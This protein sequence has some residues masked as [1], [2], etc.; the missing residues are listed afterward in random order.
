MNKILLYLHKAYDAL[1]LNYCLETLVAHGVGPWDFRLLQ[2]YL[3]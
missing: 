3:D 1:D 2:S